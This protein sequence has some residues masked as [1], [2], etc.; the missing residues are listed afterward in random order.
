MRWP[1]GRASFAAASPVRDSSRVRALQELF[2][3]KYG[4]EAWRTYFEGRNEVL[5]VDP[6]R[7]PIPPTALERI[8]GEFDS[9]A[10]GYDARIARQPIERYL[11]DRVTDLALDTLRG[12]DPILEIGPGTG[13][14]TAPLLAAGHRVVAVDLSERMLEQLQTK[15]D[16][17]ERQP[18]A[19]D[20]DGPPRGTRFGAPRPPGRLLWRRVFGVRPVRPRAGGR[21]RGHRPVTT[22]P[23]GRAAGLQ[24]P[25]STRAHPPRVGTIACPTDRRRLSYRRTGASGGT[26]ISA[27]APLAV[28]L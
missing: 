13:Y 23:A 16:R 15:A 26:P 3:A 2:R 5:E 12:L 24:F 20:P 4:A 25:Q 28:S 21:N 8:R 6:Q 27:R 10:P 11:K 7:E 18:P 17:G 9:V 14:H 1:D 19:R 22:H